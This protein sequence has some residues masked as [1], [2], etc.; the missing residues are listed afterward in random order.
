MHNKRQLNLQFAQCQKIC[1]FRFPGGDEQCSQCY[2]TI[3]PS[4]PRTCRTLPRHDD[5]WVVHMK[6]NLLP[7]FPTF[8]P[9]IQL[10]LPDTILLNTV[11]F[12]LAI[13]VCPCMEAS[14]CKMKQQVLAEKEH[15]SCEQP[16]MNGISSTSGRETL[17]ETS[18]EK[19]PLLSKDFTKNLSM[20]VFENKKFS[21]QE[22]RKIDVLRK[23]VCGVVAGSS[24]AEAKIPPKDIHGQSENNTSSTE[25]SNS[26]STQCRDLPHSTCWEQKTL[27]KTSYDVMKNP[28]ECGNVDNYERLIE[29]EGNVIKAFQF[30]SFSFKTFSFGTDS[31][32]ELENASN[33]IDGTSYLDIQVTT[34][35]GTPYNL[36]E[37]LQDSSREMKDHVSPCVH[38]RVVSLD[39]EKYINEEMNNSDELKGKY[40]LL[41]NYSTRLVDVCQDSK[42]V[43][44]NIVIL[45][46]VP[47]GKD[48]SKYQ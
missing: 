39:V 29:I 42:C 33:V 4:L 21:V 8:L 3:C 2:V 30:S 27:I 18:D 26:L 45:I 35:A 15:A 41:R 1:T 14:E 36:V 11:D 12:V 13:A 16:K 6:Y 40:W 34:V 22:T 44:I 10:Q 23:D 32:M 46:S 20:K 47:D 19:S 31:E 37:C 28:K 38:T 17:Q 24:A 7:P 25:C 5:T 9:F 48:V 43:I